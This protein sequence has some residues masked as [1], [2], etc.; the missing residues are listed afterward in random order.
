MEREILF[1]GKQIDNNEW[2]Y[3]SLVKTKYNSYIIPIYDDSIYC[4]G[5]VSVLPESVGQYTGLTDKNGTKI[6]EGDILKVKEYKNG[7]MFESMEFRDSFELQE[8]E[9]NLNKEYT[10]KVYYEECSFVIKE[11]DRCTIFL[12]ALCGNMK[13]SQPIYEFE[14]IGNMIDNT[15]LLNK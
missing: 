3:G 6:F 13:H 1:R 8:L 4:A 11:S 10:S 2:A 9:A 5:F 15:E 7:F 12:G 14:I